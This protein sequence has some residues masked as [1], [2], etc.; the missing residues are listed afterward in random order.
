MNFQ[1]AT[2]ILLSALIAC[3]LSGCD[4]PNNDGKWKID[5]IVGIKQ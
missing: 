1:K 5:A 2:A 3:Y 4:M